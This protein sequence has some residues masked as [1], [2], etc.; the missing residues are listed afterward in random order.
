MAPTYVRIMNLNSGHYARLLVYLGG[1]DNNLVS[2]KL[3]AVAIHDGGAAADE[4]KEPNKEQ[5]L[6]YHA[7]LRSRN[8]ECMRSVFTLNT[9]NHISYR[10]QTC[11]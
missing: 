9:L 4:N 10:N 3:W 7:G 11:S 8:G 5:Q 1:R 2:T 6:R